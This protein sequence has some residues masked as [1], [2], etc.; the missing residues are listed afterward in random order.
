[1]A[2]E[3]AQGFIDSVGVVTHFRYTDEAYSESGR[4]LQ[5][6]SRLGVRHIRDGAPARP[7]APLVAI[8]KDA[9]SRGIKL[10]LV[11]GSAGQSK[12]LP[13]GQ[14]ALAVVNSMNIRD[15]V[16]SLEPANEWDL[17]GG[18]TWREQVGQFQQQFFTAVRADPIWNGVPVLGPSVGRR[19]RV[20]DLVGLSAYIDIANLHNYAAGGP[21][22]DNLSAELAVARANAPGKPL[23]VTE[24]GYHT[25]TSQTD[26][27][28]PVSEQAKADYL[29]RTLL[30]NYRAGVARTFIYQ[31]VDG[32]P[33][34]SLVDQE[35]HFGLLRNDFSETPAYTEVRNLLTAANTAPSTEIG[36]TA[37]KIKVVTA[38]PDVQSL[39]L[40]RADGS[41]V[42]VVWRRGAITRGA[43]DLSRPP[44]P[45]EISTG[46]GGRKLGVWSGSKLQ[47]VGAGG[48][49]RGDLGEAPLVLDV[50]SPAGNADSIL[51]LGTPPSSAGEISGGQQ[52]TSATAPVD[53]SGIDGGYI[54]GGAVA[55]F[56]LGGLTTGFMLIRRRRGEQ[57][58]EID[59]RRAPDPGDDGK[60]VSSE[61]PE[62][63]PRR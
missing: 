26:R 14:E 55:V 1:M 9:F 25:A 61:S 7:K 32:K 8:F 46:G 35:R 29:V 58:R 10:N 52:S 15:G 33:D 23:F 5:S 50:G 3:P 30:E 63:R 16:E 53:G 22:E 56:V 37:D 59:N 31:L 2:M 24:V 6:L 57:G 42:V 27:Q 47:A 45:L 36:S 62:P 20:G 39:Q 49:V 13:S 21:P 44:I 19:Q 60:N 18:P 43:V 40:D 34:P 11:V 54:A 17:R 28:R 12:V 48:G 4:L 41:S 38:D 51:S